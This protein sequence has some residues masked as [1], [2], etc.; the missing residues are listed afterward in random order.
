MTTTMGSTSY[1]LRERAKRFLWRHQGLRKVAIAVRYPPLPSWLLVRSIEAD[2]RRLNDALRDNGLDGRVWVW[3]GLLLGWARE[4][5]VLR[6]DARDADFCIHE[7]DVDALVA[8][9]PAL[10]RAGF[11]VFRIHR[12][13]EGDLSE[14][15]LR[16]RFAHYDIFVVRDYPEAE[17]TPDWWSYK[18]FGTEDDGPLQYTALIPAQPLEP[19]DF[20]GRS[21]WKVAD[22]DR[23]LAELYGNWRVPDPT[24]D[25]MRNTRFVSRQLRRYPP[26]TS[27][28]SGE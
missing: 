12:A 16:R 10:E 8:A 11:P 21:W 27:L 9:L 26:T 15:V 19:F 22:H 25:S 20:L 17:T 24:W 7:R 6:H 4:R 28:R 23:E 18:L 3:S 14:I 2:L 5:G 1:A 13:N